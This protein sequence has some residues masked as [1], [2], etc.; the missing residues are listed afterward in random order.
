MLI[1]ITGKSDKFI[2]S[3]YIQESFIEFDVRRTQ[4]IILGF[5]WYS[6]VTFS[7]S[8]FRRMSAFSAPSSII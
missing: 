4:H 8:K 7:A 6:R 1:K 2:G 5:L 3:K